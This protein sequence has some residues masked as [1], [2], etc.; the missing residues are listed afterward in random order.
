MKDKNHLA[1]YALIRYKGENLFIR[2]ALGDS[3]PGTW[4]LP[5][6]KVDLEEGIRSALIREVKEETDLDVE[7]TKLLYAQY[8]GEFLR[9]VFR[10]KLL[11]KDPVVDLSSEHDNAI[12][13][14]FDDPVLFGSGFIHQLRKEVKL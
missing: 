8:H 1:V 2:R 7:P 3:L 11:T 4:E 14:N 10:V 13:T 9:L 6:G 5:G 12:W